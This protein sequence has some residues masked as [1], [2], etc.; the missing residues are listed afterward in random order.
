M[1][2]TLLIHV[3]KKYY[4]KTIIDAL[5]SLEDGGEDQSY[6]VTIDGG[7]IEAAAGQDCCGGGGNG[8]SGPELVTGV[9]ELI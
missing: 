8:Y 9:L 3:L 4:S 7:R 2:L 5:I 6:V 1:E